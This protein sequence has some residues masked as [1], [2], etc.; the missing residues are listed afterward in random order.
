MHVLRIA[1][2]AH[3]MA[4]ALAA[5]RYQAREIGARPGEKL[6]EEL[7]SSDEAERAIELERLLVILPPDDT[8]FPEKATR[9][10]YPDA[11][12]VRKQWHSGKDTPMSRPEIA[13]YLHEHRALEP[14]LLPGALVK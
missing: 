7:L 3:C 4:E 12:V 5:G 10:D 9:A 11:G 14:Y 8:Q 2:L 13:A 1:D 6:Y